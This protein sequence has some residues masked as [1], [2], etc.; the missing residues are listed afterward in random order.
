MI[1]MLRSDAE[2][3]DKR[4]GPCGML[5]T[6]EKAKRRSAVP[7]CAAAAVLVRQEEVTQLLAT[8]E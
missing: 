4:I 8:Y 6:S 5:N 3:E 2:S 1:G 7:Q